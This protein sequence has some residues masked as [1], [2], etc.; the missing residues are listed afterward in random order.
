MKNPPSASRPPQESLTTARDI[1]CLMLVERRL[2]PEDIIGIALDLQPEA[3]LDEIAE[4]FAVRGLRL[5][6]MWWRDDVL[7]SNRVHRLR[8][9]VNI[10]RA[11][12][13]ATPQLGVLLFAV[14]RL[15]PG[16][17]AE[18]SVWLRER[19]QL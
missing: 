2:A 13:E 14:G 8:K 4:R 9:F 6:P 12:P 10:L 3:S 5:E 17:Q 15:E 16:L 1:L 18:L 11:T 7:H 19:G